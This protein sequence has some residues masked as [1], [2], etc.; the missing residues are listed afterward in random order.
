MSKLLEKVGHQTVPGAMMVLFENQMALAEGLRRVIKVPTSV[1]YDRMHPTRWGLVCPAMRA[2]DEA[3]ARR[4]REVSKDGFWYY[5]GFDVYATEAEARDT[6]FA[7][8]LITR[9]N[10]VYDTS[11]PTDVF[12]QREVFTRDSPGSQDTLITFIAEK[13]VPSGQGMAPPAP[14]PD[15]A[16]AHDAAGEATANGARDAT[17]AA[18]QKAVPGAADAA[19]DGTGRGAGRGAADDAAH[20]AASSAADDAASGAERGATSSAEG[21]AADDA[22]RKAARKAAKKAARKAAK[23]AA[24]KEEEARERNDEAEKETG[25]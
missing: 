20:S 7:E 9:P 22:A 10:P 11:M 14:G 13:G 18:A 2:V 12:T 6:R 19:T 15:D 5:D 1:F 24:K 4:C 8:P 3:D 25:V 16:L 23:K 17:D 21:D